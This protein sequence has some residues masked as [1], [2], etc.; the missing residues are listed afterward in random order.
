VKKLIL[1]F[2]CLILA[3]P[4]Q[5]ATITVDD[6]GPADFNN[7]QAAI[8]AA[9]TGD[10]ILVA[11]GTYTG[12][13]NRDID[14][15]GK[16]ITVR[17]QSGPENCIIDCNRTQMSQGFY[18]HNGEDSNS[19]LD[20][21]TIINGFHMYGGGICCKDSS[22]PTINNCIIADAIHSCGIYCNNSSP[23]ITNCT[24][25]G[26]S[27]LSGIYCDNSS[28]TINNCI[29]TDNTAHQ[30]GGICCWDSSPIITN[31]NITGNLAEMYG[32][33][34]HCED[35]SPTITNCTISYNSTKWGEG[36]GIYCDNSSPIIKNCTINDNSA[37]EGGGIRCNYY[38]SPIIKNCTITDNSA[39]DGGGIR[40]DYCSPIINNCSITNNSATGRTGGGIDCW[41]SSPVITNCTFSANTSNKWG[42][43][44]LIG[45]GSNPSIANC[46]LWGDSAPY[47][48]EI[49]MIFFSRGS[50]ALSI[51]YSD[52]QGGQAAI[53]DIDD[54]DWGPGNIDEDPCFVIP[55]YWVDANDPNIIVEP[56]DP[57]AVWLEGDYHLLPASPCID[58]GDPNYI[59][60]PNETD[61]DGN[62]RVIGDA[63]DM[64][65]Y[66]YWPPVEAEM[67][68][69]PKA[70]NC[71]S[72]G[73][74]VKAH[75]TLPDEFLPEDVDVN[76]PA[77]A[78]PID[79]ESEYIKLLGGNPVELEIAFDRQ[80]L[81]EVLTEP[82][83]L[84]VTIIGSLT[85]GQNFY[86]TDKITVINKP[87][88]KSAK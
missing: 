64:G 62:P 2:I 15:L 26:N 12:P 71:N 4:S 73:N 80:A 10:T 57:N 85:T 16:A 53:Y 46:I 34:I 40:C 86:A 49:E 52:V 70:L 63:V 29:I 37:T 17:S 33:G 69:T 60:E 68:F 23:I 11:D 81:C 1:A 79:L 45:H 32:G 30:G 24:I 5:A 42:G 51:S 13:G 72:R 76:T 19:L 31:C 41:D 20:G 21:F 38:S 22:N 9:V 59:P 75:F 74:W 48:P 56:N 84:E 39:R 82:G 78:E 43:A 3:I 35:S 28:P 83:Q 66:E 67:N 25:T 47:G 58:T 87:D 61:L 88:E 8:D 50:T 36:G 27:D 65:A 77:W 6:D 54:L 7:I 44:V 55:G 18:F 14:F